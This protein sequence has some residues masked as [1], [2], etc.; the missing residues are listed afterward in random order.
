MAARIVEGL[1]TCLKRWDLEEKV[2]ESGH[3]WP[4]NSAK[5]RAPLC[6]AECV[7]RILCWLDLRG[8]PH[9]RM[10]GVAPAEIERAAHWTGVDGSLVSALVATGWIDED[11]EGMRWHGYGSLNRITLADRA[12]K[13][14]KRGDTTTGK[15]GTKEGTSRG[16]DPGIKEGRPCPSPGIAQKQSPGQEAEA[17][18][19]PK[20]P[21][22]RPTEAERHAEQ[23]KQAQ[24]VRAYENLVR[25]RKG[26]PPLPDLTPVP[27]SKAASNGAV[28]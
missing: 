27:V 10:Y 19:A 18:V 26:L 16:T 28:S 13:R 12:K 4:R 3:K 22:A 11:K 9:G 23:V 7:I 17:P 24:A 15:R 5:N 20:A 21:V 14:D 25:A 8:D 6:A 2:L 1:F